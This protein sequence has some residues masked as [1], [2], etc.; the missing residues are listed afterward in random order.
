MLY[1]ILFFTIASSFWCGQI[2]D[3]IRVPKELMCIAGFLA[4]HLLAGRRRSFQNFWVKG[5]VLWGF[6][7]TSFIIKNLSCFYELFYVTM[8]FLALSALATV[9]TF[10]PSVKC[11]TLRVV[12]VSFEEQIQNI[13]KFICWMAILMSCYVYIQALGWDARYIVRGYFCPGEGPFAHRIIGTFGNPTV[14]ASWYAITLPLFF[15]QKNK[16]WLGFFWCLPASLMTQG[17]IGNT[18]MI[19]AILIIFFYKN[20]KV[21]FPLFIITLTG[22]LLLF[23]HPVLKTHINPHGRINAWRIIYYAWCKGYADKN[24]DYNEK[25]SNKIP[26]DVPARSLYGYGPGQFRYIIPP[27]TDDWNVVTDEP[28]L[29]AHSEPIEIGFNYGV[30]GLILY[31]GFCF[32]IAWKFLI[33][34]KDE[35]KIGLFAVLVGYFITSLLFFPLHIGGI[36]FL[37]IL[38]IGLLMNLQG[39]MK[40]EKIVDFRSFVRTLFVMQPSL[41]SPSI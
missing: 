20:K 25:K 4:I 37:V 23:F 27:F 39:R 19:S 2:G 34:P 17:R 18:A 38:Y 13:L 41:R 16:L 3:A 36:A 33:Q 9:D 24:F 26:P 10:L 31:L 8:G 7:L 12:H 32:S 29:E 21:F 28:W 6:V 35:L 5:F 15:L 1:A 11:K 30:V 40:Y 22:I 14:L